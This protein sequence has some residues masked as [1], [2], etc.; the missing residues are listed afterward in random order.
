[1]KKLKLGLLGMF[2]VSFKQSAKLT[3]KTNDMEN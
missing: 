3:R 1:M 2:T